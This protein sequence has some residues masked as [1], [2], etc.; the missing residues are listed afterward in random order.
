VKALAYDSHSEVIRQA[1]FEGLAE[2]RDTDGIDQV[3]PWTEYG[4]PTQARTAAVK[5]LGSLAKHDEARRDDLRDHL[6]EL[7]D[8]PHFRVRRA[9]MEALGDLGDAEAIAALERSVA[10]EPAYGTRERAREALRN[11]RESDTGG[12]FVSV[13]AQLDELKETNRA[14]RQR[15]EAWESKLGTE[16]PGVTETKRP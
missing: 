2:L 15:L 14:L 4:Q 6:I 7:L 8:D 12:D 10:R 3:L 16:A 9:A 5:A 11:I 1:A 13:R